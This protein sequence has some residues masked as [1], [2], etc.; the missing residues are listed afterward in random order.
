MKKWWCAVGGLVQT[1]QLGLQGAPPS[2][3]TPVRHHS[4]AVAG[5][6]RLLSLSHPHESLE[7]LV[8]LHEAH[9]CST[10]YC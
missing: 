8:Q 9:F 1:G 2:C 5:S 7:H 4:A 6:T 3:A 10:L